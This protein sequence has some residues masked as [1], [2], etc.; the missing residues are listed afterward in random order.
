MPLA[1]GAVGE[2]L[3]DAGNVISPAAA[4]SLASSLTSELKDEDDQNRRWPLLCCD[5]HHGICRSGATILKLAGKQPSLT[6]VKA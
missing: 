3:R 1:T 4:D 6:S 5:R 2:V